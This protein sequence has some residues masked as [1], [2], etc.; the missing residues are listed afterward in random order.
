[1]KRSTGYVV[2]ALVALLLLAVGSCSRPTEPAHANNPPDT[3][4]ANIP[5]DNDTVF[6]LVTLYW[7]AGDYDGFIKGF[8]Y[9]Y[10]TYHLQ[11]GTGQWII[12]DST[13]WRDTTGAS[14][15]IPFNST[16]SL[17]RQEFYVRAVDNDGNVDPTPAKKLL[18]TTRTA[19]PITKLLTPAKNA[20]VLVSQQVTD[21]WPGVTLSFNA[22]DQAKEGAI[23]AYAWSVDDGPYTW[24]TDTSIN[25]PPS[26][27]KAPLNGSHKVKVISR[28]NTNLV[29]PVGDSSFVTLIV[30]T[31]DKQILIIDETDEFNSPFVGM[32]VSDATV[33]S[34]Y[35]TVFPGSDTWDFKSKGMPPR[36]VLAHY[37]LLIWHA[38]DV[39]VSN[40]HKISDAANIVVFT[41][42]LKVGGKFLMSGWR[43][44]KSFAYKDNFPHA[45]APGSFV[46]DYLHIITVDET[47][48]TGD[49]LGGKGK[50]GITTDF[51]VD[52]LK[53]A[54]FPYNGKLSFVNLITK[55][56]G[57]TDPLY[58]YKNLDN[59]TF[60]T[61]RGRPMALRYYGTVY[62]AVVL[63][64]P[65]Y[66]IREAD[67]KVMAQQILANLHVN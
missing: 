49:C 30:P 58:A 42:Y 55:P 57:F 40:P 36:D 13:G 4:L 7:D 31:F 20:K 48:A 11:P 19:P 44:L 37:R 21:W 47:D 60:T 33:D 2:V 39:P 23:V 64:F 56:A 43:I 15:T 35:A 14:V 65:M 16:D 3:R 25:L 54:R 62:D 41:D 27:F 9:R 50:T 22:K 34:F 38:D 46:Y 53:L 18:T 24:M 45:F 10:F 6:A 61:Y 52:S 28:N 26:A 5:R 51:A 66:F 29:D 12:F 1:M 17:N 8:Q 63:G 59:S 67:A 32:K